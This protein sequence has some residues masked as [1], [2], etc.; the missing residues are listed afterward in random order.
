M[1]HAVQSGE[2]VDNFLWKFLI[3]TSKKKILFSESFL[4]PSPA[5]RTKTKTATESRFVHILDVDRYSLTLNSI[6]LYLWINNAE[7]TLDILASSFVVNIFK[8]NSRILIPSWEYMK[9]KRRHF[10]TTKFQNIA[11][12]VEADT[13]YLYK[14]FENC[15]TST[16]W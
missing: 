6:S 9:K 13:F 7:M 12:S 3:M 8:I 2:N 15:V 11:T 5:C 1:N 14:M 4:K 16:R 10:I